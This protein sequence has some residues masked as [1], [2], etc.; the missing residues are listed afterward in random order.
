MH[1]CDHV[2]FA[3]FAFFAFSLFISFNFI[4]HYTYSF[5]RI[6]LVIFACASPPSCIHSSTVCLGMIR[7][8]TQNHILICISLIHAI[9]VGGMMIHFAV[10]NLLEFVQTPLSVSLLFQIVKSIK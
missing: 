4:F 8:A 1:F 5:T 3:I 2:F 6:V 10:L 9:P 7:L